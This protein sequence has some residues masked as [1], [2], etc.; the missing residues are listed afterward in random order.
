MEA[1]T[2]SLPARCSGC[3][4]V[5]DLRYDLSQADGTGEALRIIRAKALQLPLLCWDCRD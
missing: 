1:Q 2:L 5:F 3:G 4:N